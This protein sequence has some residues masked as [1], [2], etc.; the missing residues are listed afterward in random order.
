MKTN[1]WIHTRARVSIDMFDVDVF[2]EHCPWI[3]EMEN[4]TELMIAWATQGRQH[5]LSGITDM[6][7]V[8][9]DIDRKM[10]ARLKPLHEI[11][12]SKVSSTKGKAG[13]LLYENWIGSEITKCWDTECT[14]TQPHCGDFIHTHYDTKQKV[15]V[16]V[17][18]YSKNVP[19]SEV[20]KLWNDMEVQCIPLG[21]I[22]SMSTRFAGH[23]DGMDI[24][25]R[26]IHGNPATMI[27][28]SNALHRK[29]LLFIALEILRLHNPKTT[30]DIEDV[31]RPL[32]GILDIVAECETNMAKMEKDV[33]GC[34]TNFRQTTHAH[35]LS[36]QSILERTFPDS[37]R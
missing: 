31:L 19:K 5:L 16:D 8:V 18:N 7:D 10:E 6:D 2:L 28:V 1:L 9:D 26:T 29:E 24:E 17:K 34:I 14:K 33:V 25:F 3:T 22:V 30:F 27:L 35:Y 21:L 37:T 12:T 4:G 32:R 36:I 15:I 11:L 20:E 13:E 23:R